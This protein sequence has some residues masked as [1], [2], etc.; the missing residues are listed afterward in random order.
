MFS[1]DSVTEAE[2]GKVE[3]RAMCDAESRVSET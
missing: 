2:R 3:S 1:C